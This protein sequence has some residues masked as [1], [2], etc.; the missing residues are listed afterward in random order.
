[1]K[2]RKL[3]TY[4]CNL[5]LYYSCEIN[6]LSGFCFHPQIIGQYV[7]HLMMRPT[8]RIEGEDVSSV[9]GVRRVTQ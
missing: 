5:S 9:K 3:E 1:M 4:Q 2:G 6:A 8:Q 7:Y